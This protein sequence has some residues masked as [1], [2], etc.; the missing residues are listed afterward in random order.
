LLIL[1]R[2]KLRFARF[3]SGEASRAVSRNVFGDEMPAAGMP[4]Y[5]PTAKAGANGVCPAP[6]NPGDAGVSVR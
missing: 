1:F 3:F 6:R 2:A 5:Q 4:E